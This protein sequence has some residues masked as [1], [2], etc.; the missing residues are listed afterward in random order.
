[1]YF[2]VIRYTEYMNRTV[3]RTGFISKNRRILIISGIISLLLIILMIIFLAVAIIR[4]LSNPMVVDINTKQSGTAQI[5]LQEK[6]RELIELVNT[7]L[8]NAD[9]D[10]QIS[11]SN[12]YAPIISDLLSSSPVFITS[13]EFKDESVILTGYYTQIVYVPFSI[14]IY[15]HRFSPTTDYTIRKVSLFN[16]NLPLLLQSIL[17]SAIHDNLSINASSLSNVE[18][19]SWEIKNSVLIITG[20]ILE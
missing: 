15:S 9:P 1:M 13:V 6:R 17:S 4:S 3:A 2:R 16:R 8:R 18:I 12:E 7:A 14:E 20:R 11:L 5:V 19:K 10:F